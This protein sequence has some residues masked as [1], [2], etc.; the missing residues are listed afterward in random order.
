MIATLVIA[1][2]NATFGVVLKLLFLPLTLITLGL[3]LVVINALLLKLASL[4]TP[5]FAVRGFLP[6]ALGSVVL[7]VLTAI[8]RFLVFLPRGGWATL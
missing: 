7:T 5:G 6:A 2:V 8:L 4:F 3:F 1:V